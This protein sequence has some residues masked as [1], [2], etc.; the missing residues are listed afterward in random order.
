MSLA[1]G[2]LRR[3]RES[4]SRWPLWRLSPQLLALIIAVD[5]VGIAALVLSVAGFTSRS[6]DWAVFGALLACALA[7]AEMSRKLGRPSGVVKDLASAWTLPMIFLLPQLYALLAIG[8]LRIHMHYRLRRTAPHRSVFTAASVA[9]GM[10]A[11]GQLFYHLAP[12]GTTLAGWTYPHGA[13]V[14]WALLCAAISAT[15]NST[16]VIMAVWLSEPGS[17]TWRQFLNAETRM[18]D[19]VEI[20]SGILVTVVRLVNPYL[21]PVMLI[22]MLVLQRSLMHDQLR[23]Q[24]RLD[25]KTGLLNAGTWNREAEREILA[26]GRRKSQAALILIDLDHFKRVN[27]TY[28]HL[29]GDQV[30]RA[31]AGVLTDQ[32]RR[33]DLVGRFGGEELCLLLPDTGPARSRV[34]AE[35]LHQQIGAL[36]VDPAEETT[37]GSGSLPPIRVTASIGVALLGIDGND[38]TELLAAADAALYRAKHL[39]RNRTCLASD[40]RTG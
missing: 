24:A 4:L 15:I 29:V 5:S 34:V 1:L 31:V 6:G 33:S 35:R 28:G 8:A 7:S 26:A 19:A 36:V 16:L 9:I 11:A 20:S 40:V 10:V 37:S 27:D 30:L 2:S 23:S 38:V 12:H 13:A 3:R 39:G 22:P 17:I 18:L 25:A 14:G 21:L 32:V